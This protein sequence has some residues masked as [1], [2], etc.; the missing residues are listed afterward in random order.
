MSFLAGKDF[1]GAVN[2]SSGGTVSVRDILDH[3]EKRTGKRA[4]ID[5]EGDDAPY[6]GEPEYSINTDKA[7]SLGFEFSSVNDWIYGLLDHFINGL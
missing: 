5:A 7:E 1:N 6:N 2:G 3:V 4:V